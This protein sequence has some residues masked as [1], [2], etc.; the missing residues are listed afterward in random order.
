MIMY[1][2]VEVWFHS[3]LKS[4]VAWMDFASTSRLG[5]F[6]FAKCHPPVSTEWEAR[7]GDFLTEK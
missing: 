2:G 1:G 4:T 6:P 7:S 5:L 3:F